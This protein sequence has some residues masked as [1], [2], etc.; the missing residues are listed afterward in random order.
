MRTKQIAISTALVVI[1]WFV[2]FGC[3]T[4]PKVSPLQQTAG[5]I[6]LKNPKNPESWVE[7]GRACFF[8]D[9][10][11]GAEMAFKQALQLDEKYLPGYKHL[12]LVL[13]KLQRYQDAQK[14]YEQAIRVSDGDSE[15]WTAYGYCLVDVGDSGGAS[16]AFRRSVELNTDPLSVISAR[17]GAA[18]LLH[19]QGNK[20]ALRREYEETLK[21]NPEVA[22]ILEQ[23]KRE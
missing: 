13:V 16:K 6:V 17:L 5:E 20:N 22:R 11:Q 10:S 14:V 21:I 2:L 4:I 9:N 15:L 8:S 1:V 12:G 7:Y 19:R 23:N 18:A 3:A